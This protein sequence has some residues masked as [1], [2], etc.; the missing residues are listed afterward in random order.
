MAID[1]WL[2]SQHHLGEHPPC[3]RF[4]QWQPAAISYGYHQKDLPQHWQTLAWA[5]DPLDLV[6][7]PTGGRA[8]LHQGDLTYALVRSYSN[9]SRRQAYE[10]LSQFLIQGFKT[11]GIS[12]TLGSDQGQ[13]QRN[14]NCFASATH[15]D[16]VLEDGYKLIGSAQ[17]WNGT[18]VLQH[19][20]I[21][22]SPDPDLW[23][24]VFQAPFILPNHHFPS[25]E[26]IITTL[27]QA[28][29]DHFGISL[30]SE[31]LTSEEWSALKSPDIA[32]N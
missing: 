18:T 7:R 10:Q 20:S 17:A 22:L 6:R 13:Y 30:Y 29:A 27:S 31:P 23:E 19:G 9:R 5:G 4:Y 12:L 21:R 3:L 11:L 14:V 16:L 2:W 28:L 8:V 1:A 32:H 26:I 25:I 15:A 24:Q